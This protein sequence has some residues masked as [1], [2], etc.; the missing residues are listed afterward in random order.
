MDKIN[1]IFKTALDSLQEKKEPEIIRVIQSPTFTPPVISSITDGEYL[2]S[3]H[4]YYENNLLSYRHAIETITT[5]YSKDR[6]ESYKSPTQ[7]QEDF[8]AIPEPPTTHDSKEF[9]ALQAQIKDSEDAYHASRERPS[10]ASAPLKSLLSDSSKKI[11][12]R[13]L[14]TAEEIAGMTRPLPSIPELMDEM[15][16]ASHI[17]KNT[18]DADTK[19]HATYDLKHIHLLIEFREKPN[20]PQYIFNHKNFMPIVNKLNISRNLLLSNNLIN[21]KVDCSIYHDVFF[22]SDIHAD[23]R[24][25]ISLLHS[26]GFVELGFDPYSDDIYD[27]NFINRIRWIKNNSL[28]VIIGDLVDG[29]RTSTAPDG[30]TVDS[31][32]VNDKIGNFEIL[33]HILIHNLRLQAL[34]LNSNI[35]FTYGN[36][37]IVS[38]YKNAG[39]YHV[40]VSPETKDY[41]Y[42]LMQ[43]RTNILKYF[44][45]L[46]PYIILQL[47]TPTNSREILCVHGGLH[48]DDAANSFKHFSITDFLKFQEILSLTGVFSIDICR[49]LIYNPTE[50]NEKIIDDSEYKSKDD[51][52]SYNRFKEQAGTMLKYMYSKYFSS[53]DNNWNLLF[54]RFYA[55]DDRKAICDSIKNFGDDIKMVVVGHCQTDYFPGLATTMDK[56]PKYYEGCEKADRPNDLKGCVVSD[57]SDI[58]NPGAPTLALVDTAMSSAFRD[59]PFGEGSSSKL[60]EDEKRTAAMKNRNR[61]NEMLHL[62]HD[63]T[64]GG[65]NKYYNMV[66]R[67]V[68]PNQIPIKESVYQT[69]LRVPTNPEAASRL[70]D[71]SYPQEILREPPYAPTEQINVN[72]DPHEIVL[73]KAP[74]KAEDAAR[75]REQM[76]YLKYKLKY[77]YLVQKS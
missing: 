46:S 69:N 6:K 35:L 4:R 56:I 28:L 45:A 29:T 40:Y 7:R 57:C 66:L 18:T 14:I 22:T 49:E 21:H 76:K 72:K 34:L 73:Y 50:I 19:R 67:L 17:F 8:N 13:L 77:Y 64:L 71:T 16:R 59:R 61:Y 37:D 54:N 52:D 23:L 38:I 31:G 53:E 33:L 65:V 70:Y 60:S 55:S 3:I 44:Y 42:N 11:I 10:T 1:D 48:S 12:P 51:Y 5:Y 41:L 9:A 30:S 39:K 43:L 32:T 2:S 20:P 58:Q 27:P 63:P 15:T 36:H 68:L 75:Y 62:H 24:K 26:G 25:F 74:P 47:S